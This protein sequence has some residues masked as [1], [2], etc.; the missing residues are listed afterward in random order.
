MVELLPCCGAALLL[1]RLEALK[2]QRN[3]EIRRL[4]RHFR[5]KCITRC[6]KSRFN[7]EMEEKLWA[8][9]CQEFLE[10]YNKHREAVTV[11]LFYWKVQKLCLGYIVTQCYFPVV[12]SFFYSPASN[13]VLYWLYKNGS[14]P[15]TS[16][17]QLLYYFL[18]WSLK[19]HT[20]VIEPSVLHKSMCIYASVKYIRDL[21]VVLYLLRRILLKGLHSACH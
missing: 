16:E 3:F 6:Q 21:D 11:T 1:L 18:S 15:F 7:T 17:I 2:Y 9:R 10:G 12:W 14:F 13:N 20:T 19:K 8:D 4:P 5:V